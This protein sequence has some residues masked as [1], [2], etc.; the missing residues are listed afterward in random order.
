MTFQKQHYE[1]IAKIIK[2]NTDDHYDSEEGVC[3]D[4]LDTDLITQLVNYFEKDNP[5]F[6]KERFLKACG[7]QNEI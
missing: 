3:F 5:K 6:D 4:F 1:A 2:E 7:G